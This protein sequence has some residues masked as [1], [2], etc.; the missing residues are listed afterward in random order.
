[1][2]LQLQEV[3]R[4]GEERERQAAARSRLATAEEMKSHYLNCLH[5]MVNTGITTPL[6][7]YLHWPILVLAGADGNGQITPTSAM[8]KDGDTVVGM[9]TTSLD[10]SAQRVCINKGVTSKKV[11]VRGAALRNKIG[12]GPQKG[13]V[14]MSDKQTKLSVASR[15]SQR[16]H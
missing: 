12:G 6:I 8:A 7:S 15:Q 4:V 13:S 9:T 1:M 11:S 14:G 5:M 3:I 16:R 2:P 10:N